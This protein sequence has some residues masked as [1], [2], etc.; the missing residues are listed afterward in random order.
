MASKTIEVLLPGELSGYVQRMVKGGRYQDASEVVREALR[1][2]EAAELADE[3]NQFERAFAGGHDRSETEDDIR[4]VEAAVQAGGARGDR[5][6]CARRASCT[7]WRS[8]P[9]TALRDEYTRSSQPAAH[10]PLK[11][12]N[13]SVPS[14]TLST[15]PTP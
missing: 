9:D 12:W 15:G 8:T 14:A 7:G 6:C 5:R 13:W 3:V 1:R 4:R 2:M 10:S 11:P